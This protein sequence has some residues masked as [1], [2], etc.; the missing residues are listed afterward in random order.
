[1]IA[2]TSDK[3]L[4]IVATGT[5]EFAAKAGKIAWTSDKWPYIVAI[6]GN[7]R[8]CCKG[9]EDCLDIRWVLYAA[10]G[11][12]SLTKIPVMW[13]AVR[14]PVLEV[15]FPALVAPLIVV[16]SSYSGLKGWHNV[17]PRHYVYLATQMTKGIV[18]IT[19]ILLQCTHTHTLTHT[20]T[21]THTHI[22]IPRAVQSDAGSSAGNDTAQCYQLPCLAG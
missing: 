4:C 9:L 10:K 19:M 8:I 2:W 14:Q 3:W 17:K 15:N 16:V 18:K 1:M 5:I 11:H 12:C 20:H 13:I 7:N 21:N 6:Y 22:Q